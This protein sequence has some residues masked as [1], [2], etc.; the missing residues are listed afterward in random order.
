MVALGKALIVTEV[1]PEEAEQLLL[2][3]TVTFNVTEPEAPAVYVILFVPVP[4][5]MLPLLIVH[6]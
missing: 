3:V 2:F 5:V 4:A 1:F 6:A